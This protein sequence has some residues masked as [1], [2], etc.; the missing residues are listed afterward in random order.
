MS[1]FPPVKTQGIS[2]GLQSPVPTQDYVFWTKIKKVNKFNTNK[3]SLWPLQNQANEFLSQ[4]QEYVFVLVY[5]VSFSNYFL[6][7]LL[8]LEK[9]KIQL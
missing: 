5:Q 9:H 7:I 4:E 2:L 1:P 8:Q 3:M 6:K